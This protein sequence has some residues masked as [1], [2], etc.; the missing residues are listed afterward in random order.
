MSV[1]T[2]RDQVNPF[3][4]RRLYSI[5]NEQAPAKLEDVVNAI[6]VV[7]VIVRKALTGCLTWMVAT[8]NLICSMYTHMPHTFDSSVSYTSQWKKKKAF[9]E[10]SVSNRCLWSREEQWF[11]WRL[12]PKVWSVIQTNLSSHLGMRFPL[13][14]VN[15]AWSCLYCLPN[16]SLG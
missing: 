5:K 12:Y 9:K 6:D 4:I 15:I 7:N 1:S 16:N 11:S 3:L 10:K 2:R 13:V 8:Q 14:Y